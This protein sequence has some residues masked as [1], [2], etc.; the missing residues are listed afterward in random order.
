MSSCKQSA[1]LVTSVLNP[2]EMKLGIL[3]QR[4]HFLR[5]ASP[6]GPNRKKGHHAEKSNH[7]NCRREEQRV[8]KAPL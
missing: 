7:K 4:F 2:S 5:Q 8:G 3:R 1:D 6:A